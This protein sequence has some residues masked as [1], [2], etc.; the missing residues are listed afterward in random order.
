VSPD[1]KPGA[2][3]FDLLMLERLRLATT[4]PGALGCFV[5]GSKGACAR[6]TFVGIKR[7]RAAAAW[8]QNPA[9]DQFFETLLPGRRRLRQ[10]LLGRRDDS[11]H[12]T[13]WMHYERATSR[14]APIGSKHLPIAGCPKWKALSF[15]AP[16]TSL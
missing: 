11:H 8:W 4:R 2:S 12:P 9:S 1:N 3:A 7:G 15:H 6:L 5:H 14:R 16:K 10:R 13:A